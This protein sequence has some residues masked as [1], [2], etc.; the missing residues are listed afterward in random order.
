MFSSLKIME[1][2]STLI[3]EQLHQFALEGFTRGLS[4]TLVHP[5]TTESI[6]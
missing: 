3:S 4:V 6:G 2:L 1:Y 5:T